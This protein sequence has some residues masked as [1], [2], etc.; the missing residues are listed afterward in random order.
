[1]RTVRRPR[2]DG[3][4]NSSATSAERTV[5]A[6]LHAR[7]DAPAVLARDLRSVGLDGADLARRAG[8]GRRAGGRVGDILGGSDTRRI[9]LDAV[10]A[11]YGEAVRRTGDRWLGLRLGASRGAKWLGPLGDVLARSPTVLAA[12]DA[13]RRFV[14]LL[15][16]GQQIRTRRVGSGFRLQTWLPDGLDRA[17]A[18]VILQ[19]TVVLMAN[20]VDE[21][22]LG[23]FL[24]LTLRF[25]C[26][27]PAALGVLASVVRPGRALLFGQHEWSLELP[28]ACL[29]LE[30]RA[31]A[32][33]G[34]RRLRERLE[35]ELGRLQRTRGVL[36]RLRLQLLLDLAQGPRL[37][38]T[39]RRLGMAPRTLQLR[40]EAHRTT[41]ARE[42][43][44]I[45]VE[46]AR[47]YLAGTDE[48]VAVVAERVGL[49][50]ASA[51]SRFLRAETGRPP[52][53]FRS[54]RARGPEAGAHRRR[55]R[56]GPGRQ[57]L[58]RA[59]DQR[60]EG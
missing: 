39:A 45:R 22:V 5:F 19:S 2:H 24:P 30:P 17:G 37:A 38:S 16:A 49:R 23:P 46:L 40:L 59:D 18:E 43:A 53:A 25:A 12:I 33:G 54:P 3:S 60:H 14:A 48:P 34:Q 42:L 58:E 13:A 44:R 36:A 47:R 52:V 57:G 21:L 6:E 26:E 15:V 11:A 8:L 7:P 50:S 35:A 51:L 55:D 29:A 4:R 31:A 32:T 28:V 9:P 41:F 20:V 56:A 27:R 1:M 10:A